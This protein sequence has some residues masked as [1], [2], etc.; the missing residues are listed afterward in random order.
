MTAPAFMALP[1]EVHSA[2]LSS[3]PGP[4][5]VLAAAGTWNALSAEYASVAAELSE[6]L[7]AVQAGAWQGPSAESYEAANAP[8]LAWLA[9]ASADSA[10]VAAQHETVA[11]AYTAALAAMPTL[12]ELTTNHTVH[13]VL[14]A[15]NFFGVNTVPIALNEADYARMWVQAATTMS[16][17]QAVAGSAAASTPETPAAPAILKSA[18]SAETSDPADPWGPAH[19]WNDPFLE[20]IAQ[21]L[22][23]VGVNWEPGSGT[24][25]GLPYSTFTNP[26]TGLYWVKNTVT[27]IQEVDYVI[28]NVGAH[29]E[30]ALLLLNPATLSSFLIAHPLVAIEL[31]AAISSSLTAPLGS[32]S[33]FAALAALPWLSDV[34]ILVDAVPDAVA[35]PVPSVTT[36]SNLHVVSVAGSVPATGSP[37]AGLPASASAGAGAPA[38]APAAVGGAG[39]A[40]PYLI[41]FGGG[42]GIGFDSSNKTG[43]G[44][45]AR[46][47]SPAS[48]SAA[49]ESAARRQ[50]RRR[51]RRRTQLHDHGDQFADMNVDPE[52]ASPD[53]SPNASH[54]SAGQLGFGGSVVKHDVREAGL[55]TLAG[56]SFS[57]LPTEP[58]MPSTWTGQSGEGVDHRPDH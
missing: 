36:V 25:N 50:A 52:W 49:E 13:G 4:G 2:L 41:G 11:A 23:Y 39:A 42:P 22:R 30:V 8:Y 51:R 10:T 46:A 58:L 54:G 29:P 16:T 48:D 17:Y 33:A 14:L 7:T 53:D 12:A 47:K 26:L 40:L 38:P 32:L 37:A 43:S 24:I 28:A 56:D 6:V 18:A 31:G 57:G 21:V 34:P 9:Q 27:L 20:G 5:P 44:T 15:T 45:G 3:G 35:A 55:T 19:T 1:P